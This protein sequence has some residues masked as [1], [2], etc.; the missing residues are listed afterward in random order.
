MS[1]L[2]IKTERALRR[3]EMTGFWV[4]ISMGVI[5]KKCTQSGHHDTI[6]AQ[7]QIFNMFSYV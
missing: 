3:E 6:V 2:R 5:Y 1:H 4:I 7:K